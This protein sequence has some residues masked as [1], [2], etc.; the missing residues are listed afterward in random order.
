TSS[1]NIDFTPR[2]FRWIR[3]NLR[4]RNTDDDVDNFDLSKE[5]LDAIESPIYGIDATLFAEEGSLKVVT[6]G[7]V[8]QEG[9]ILPKNYA[10]EPDASGPKTPSD[11]GT[12]D[13]R[14]FF[15]GTLTEEE[16]TGSI[17]GWNYIAYVYDS[18]LSD[19]SNSPPSL[20]PSMNLVSLKRK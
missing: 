10:Y 1:C 18:N 2:A 15:W 20:P 9:T 7:G 14:L 17:S 3:L 13:R 16:W 8:D 12:S 6:G 11:S 5:R 19:P 4:A